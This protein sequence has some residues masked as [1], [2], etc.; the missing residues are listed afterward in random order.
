MVFKMEN[1]RLQKLRDRLAENELD[2]I[3]VSQPE[4]RRYLSGFDGS[5]AFLLISR[6]KAVLATDF[7]YT[8]QAL[9]QAPDYEILRIAN[10]IT[11]WFPGLVSDSKV[12]RLGFEAGDITIDLHQ[13]LTDALHKKKVLTELVPVNGL[14]E[15]LRLVKEPGEIELI[16]KVHLLS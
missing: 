9:N 10:N 6:G 8:E 14:V 1:S 2:A 11:D 13:K 12:K 3:M 7:R 15:A 16:K 4:N 5:S